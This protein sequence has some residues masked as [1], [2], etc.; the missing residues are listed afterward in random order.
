MLKKESNLTIPIGSREIGGEKL[1]FVIEEGLA[2]LG[3]FQKALGMIDAAALSKADA[4][5]FQMFRAIDVYRK[6]DPAYD[7]CLKY[8]FSPSQIKDLVKY[9]KNKGLEFIAVLLSPKLVDLLVRAGCAGFNINASDLTNPVI[10]DAAVDS[11][12]PFYLGLPMASEREVEWAV[13]RIRR[14]GKNIFALLQGQHTMLSGGSGVDISH[15]ALGCMR[16]LKKK[17]AVPVGFIDHTSFPW[18]PAAA[19]AAGADFVCKHLALSRA[20]RG[21][22]W[23]VCLEPGEMKEA[24][25]WARQMKI[26]VTT[27]VKELAPGENKDRCKMRRS[28]VASRTIPVGKRVERGDLA[29][30]RPGT[31]MDPSQFETIIGKTVVRKIKADEQ[32][33]LADLKGGIR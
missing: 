7:N 26:S 28:I 21:P 20:D 1:F 10:I 17:Y 25:F 16:T 19:V 22:D 30:K 27:Q 8:E 13:N 12:L 2:N 5:E 33:M 3:D 32:I 11:G 18:M 9:T 23:Q 24:V 15:T 29:F 6:Q 14:K 4:I 31:G